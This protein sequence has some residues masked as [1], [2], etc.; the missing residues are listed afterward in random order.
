MHYV[1]AKETVD[2]YL[3]CRYVCKYNVGSYYIYIYCRPV[4]DYYIIFNVNCL[5]IAE[6][7]TRCIYCT[8]GTTFLDVYINLSTRFEKLNF[9]VGI[10]YNNIIVS[11]NVRLV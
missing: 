3:L 11:R 1:A 4:L 9:H 5:C 10:Y 2:E 8:C 7:N 6:D